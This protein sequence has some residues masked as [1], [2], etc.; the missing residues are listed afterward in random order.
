MA[1]YTR[2]KDLR[3]NADKTQ[4]DVA[5]YLGTTAQYYGKYEK[6]ERELPFSRAIQLAEYYT[7]TLDCL[8]GRSTS[9]SG[10][11]LSSDE[12]ALLRSR[13]CLSERNKGKIEFHIEE[14]NGEKNRRK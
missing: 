8:A 2:L 14:R 4:N 12:A 13:N 9:K 7:V 5:E 3:E 10:Q 11:P 6:G 1:L